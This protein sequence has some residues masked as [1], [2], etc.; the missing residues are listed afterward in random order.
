[1]IQKLKTY[2]PFVALLAILFTSACKKDDSSSSGGGGGNGSGNAEYVLL[3]ENGAQSINLGGSATY[4]AVLVNSQGQVTPATGVTWTTSDQEVATISASGAITTKGTG[5]ITV[6]AAVTVGG[7][8]YTCTV[9]LGIAPPSVFAVAPSAIIWGVND[10]PLQL[11][12]IYFGTS[13]SKY[14]Y[15]SSNS[16]IASVSNTGLVSFHA[17]G[18]CKITVTAIELD[19]TPEVI[20]PVMVVGAPAIPLPI[21]K[22]KVTPAAHDM[23]RGETKQ[24]SAKAYNANNEEVTAAF[25][26]EVTDNTIGTINTTGLFTANKIGKTTIQVTAQGITGQAEVVV[27]PD[28]LI[29][30]NPMFVS[31][32]AGGTQQF[33]A[34]TY[35]VNRTTGELSL[36]NNPAG[37]KWEMPSYGISIFD[38]GSIDNNGKVTIKS[39]AMQGLQAFVIAHVDGVESIE[40]GVGVISVGVAESCNCGANNPDVKTISLNKTSMALGFGEQDK[41][42]AQALNGASQPVGNATIVYCS[43]NDMV[44]TVD[45]EGNVSAMGAGKAKITVCVGNVK[46]YVNVDVTF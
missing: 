41:I 11:E 39:D 9:P 43:D 35:K 2:L 20:V 6:T 15:E 30:V 5:A 22:I 8:N 44:A 7:V 36:I 12:T 21:V 16:N 32:S 26:W 38:V 17:V 27:N 34:K 24:F 10:G 19:G 25:T 40:P 29:I 23:F 45:S 14:T 3:I 18:S 1:M 28:T 31:V 46:A 4:S 13:S 42:T 37:L 33:T